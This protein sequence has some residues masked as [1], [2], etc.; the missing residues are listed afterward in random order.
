[1]SDY[2]KLVRKVHR[3]TD[4]DKYEGLMLRQIKRAG[5]P[6][7]VREYR[8]SP[9]RRWRFDFAWPDL[10]I[11]LEVEGGT[12]AN[13]RH[14]RGS[15]YRKDCEKYNTAALMGWKVLRV[16]GDMVK[17]KSAIEFVVEALG[18]NK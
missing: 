2:R 9:P 16:T 18:V 11:A 17:D 12:W 8:F 15:G 14:N 13:G 1:M 7:P 5:L 10:M 4:R 3:V 6:E